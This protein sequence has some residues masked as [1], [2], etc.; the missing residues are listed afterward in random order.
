M[1]DYGVNIAVAVKNTQAITKLSRDT[2]LLGQKI[3]NVND[4][5]EKF[6]DLNGKTVVNS[7]AN[8]NRELAKAAEN[9]NDV[10]LGSDRAADAARNFARAQDLANEALREQAAL[11]AEVRNQGRS[12]TLRGGTQYGGP[13][14][15]GPASSTALS[16]PLPPSVPVALKSPMRPQSLLPQMGMTAQAGKIASDMEDVYASILRLTEKANQEEA[17]KLQ[18]LRKGTEEVEKLAQKYRTVTNT[19]KT[20][21]QIQ[22]EIRRNIL[23]TKKAAAEEARI[24]NQDFWID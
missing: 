5:L 8:F 17:E 2:D 12:G 18:T 9:F 14:G 19:N 1:A 16:S 6:G 24:A 20:Q 4:A 3:K 23:E 11:L 10:R 7:V 13:I 22:L 21:K 15:P